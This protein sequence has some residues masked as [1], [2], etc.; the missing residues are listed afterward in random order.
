MKYFML[1]SANPFEILLLSSLAFTFYQG[2]VTRWPEGRN[3]PTVSVPSVDEPAA[4]G[5][6][7]ARLD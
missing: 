7:S 3:A 4:A 6:S 2:D 1:E 5:S